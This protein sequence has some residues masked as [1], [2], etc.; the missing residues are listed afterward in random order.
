MCLE[1][2]FFFP[3]AKVGGLIKD[4]F[5]LYKCCLSSAMTSLRKY[6]SLLQR[7]K[8]QDENWTGH[9]QYKIMEV[10]EQPGNGCI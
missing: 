4:M 2:P 3:P 6:L 10:T 7:K 9:V 5:P 1:A 8:E